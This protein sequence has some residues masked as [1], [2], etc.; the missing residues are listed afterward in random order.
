M[1]W[2]LAVATVG[3]LC[4]IALAC[5]RAEREALD[6]GER[7]LRLVRGEESPGPQPFHQ[8]ARPLGAEALTP[9]T[10]TNRSCPGLP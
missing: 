4:S 3:V 5:R 9:A 1:T 8:P 7:H 2:I 10:L 6:R